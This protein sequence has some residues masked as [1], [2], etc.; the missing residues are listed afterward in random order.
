MQSIKPYLDKIKKYFEKHKNFSEKQ[1]NPNK[2]WAIIFSLFIISIICLI[3]FSIIL[4]FRIQNDKF[5]QSEQP[6]ILNRNSLNQKMFDKVTKEFNQ[7][8]EK[9][10]DLESSKTVIHDPSL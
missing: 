1:I 3:V 5:L 2:H 6:Q 9:L 7:K 8:A 4:L 10:Q